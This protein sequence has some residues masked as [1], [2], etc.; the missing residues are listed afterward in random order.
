MK[1]SD[2]VTASDKHS[3]VMI[4]QSLLHEELKL[5]G[6]YKIQCFDADGNLKWEDT[7]DNLIT[8]QG[9]NHVLDTELGGSSYTA[10]WYCS[11]YTAGTITAAATYAVPVVTE[12]TSGVL[13]A[14]VAVTFAA[15]SGGSKVSNTINCVFVGGATITGMMISKGSA[16][17]G[18]T[19]TAGGVLLSAALLTQ[20]RI[21]VANDQLNLTYTQTLS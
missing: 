20:S 12:V 2:T 7:V 16:T 3:D 8:T 9:K 4:M 1:I 5:H 17:I 21:V 11:L 19:A 10:A 6:Q 15:A 13:A 18:D 14:R